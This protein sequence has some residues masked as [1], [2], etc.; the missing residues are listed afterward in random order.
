MNTAIQSETASRGSLA[1]I[2]LLLFSQTQYNDV[3]FVSVVFMCLIVCIS[4]SFVF[5][6][7]AFHWCLKTVNENLLEPCVFEAAATSTPT[8]F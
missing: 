2:T 5:T 4:I 3:H 7:S 6:V 1:Q 8:C